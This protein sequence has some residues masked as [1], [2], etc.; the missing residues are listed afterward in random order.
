[1]QP[2]VKIIYT[3][4]ID[5]GWT[6]V[7]GKIAYVFL[8]IAFFGLTYPLLGVF[9]GG[10]GL[11]DLKDKNPTKTDPGYFLNFRCPLGSTYCADGIEFCVSG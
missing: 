7:R 10:G 3:M 4:K 2:S 8:R 11:R 5:A 1:M 9:E 6:K